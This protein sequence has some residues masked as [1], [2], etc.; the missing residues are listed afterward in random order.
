[1][2][3]GGLARV[4]NRYK[5][6]LVLRNNI[7]S[8]SVVES[9]DPL[10][11]NFIRLLSKKTDKVSIHRI[12]CITKSYYIKNKVTRFVKDDPIFALFLRSHINA[13]KECLN[14]IRESEQSFREMPLLLSVNKQPS[15]NHDDDNNNNNNE[16][17]DTN[18]S[19]VPGYASSDSQ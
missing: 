4:Y 14:L 2:L 15:E 9:T 7:V 1:M 6:I 13:D 19:S 16:Y 11:D 10:S 8:T 12:W 18:S 5:Q 17:N 3:G